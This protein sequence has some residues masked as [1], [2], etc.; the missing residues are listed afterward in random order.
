M[1]PEFNFE[2]HDKG[3]EAKRFVWSLKGPSGGVH[4]WAQFSPDLGGIFGGKCYGGI[5]VHHKVKPYEHCPDEAP[6]KDCWLTGCDCWPDGSSLFFDEQLR[7]LVEDYE[8]DPERLTAT[9]NAE[10]LSWYRSHL[11]R[12][13]FPELGAAGAS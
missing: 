10:M 2:I 11:S 3:G 7:P 8:D 6:I 5:E 1:K 12:A 13:D 4:I 9:M